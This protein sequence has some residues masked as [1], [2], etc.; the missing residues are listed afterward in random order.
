MIQLFAITA[1]EVCIL[2]MMI[3]CAVVAG[4]VGH[5][6]WGWIGAIGGALSVF[7]APVALAVL[8]SCVAAVSKFLGLVKPLDSK[9]K[10]ERVTPVSKD[11]KG[12]HP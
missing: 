3:A 7:V 5:F 8:L 1:T 4:I 9:R 12:G 10:N 6:I 11:G 2:Q